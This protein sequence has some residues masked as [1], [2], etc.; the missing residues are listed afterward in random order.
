MVRHD[1]IVTRT[2]AD[3]AMERY[4]RGDD[5]AFAV[6]YDE[7]AP[8]LRRYL[9]RRS[10]TDELSQD[11]L[12]ET[13]LHIHRGRGSF[14]SG[15][16]VLPWSYAIARR[17]LCDAHRH[18]QRRPMMVEVEDVCESCD[19]GGIASPEAMMVARELCDGVNRLLDEM[20]ESQR[21]AFELLRVDG[22]STQEAAGR[23]GTSVTAVKL[24]AHRAYESLRRSLR[25]DA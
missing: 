4:A 24:R 9:A 5:A 12:Q 20:P 16:A 25:G 2:P 10:A 22:A 19:A 18:H 1:P 21:I 14:I 3:A 6:V 13:M 23:L 8:Y 17:L 11:L 7:I 15:S